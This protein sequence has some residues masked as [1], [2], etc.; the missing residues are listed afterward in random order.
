MTELLQN[1]MKFVQLSIYG[2]TLHHYFAKGDRC[3][4]AHLN[5][6]RF[7]IFNPQKTMRHKIIAFFVT[8]ALMQ[9]ALAAPGI[10]LWSDNFNTADTAD[11]NAAS[12]TGRLSGTLATSALLFSSIDNDGLPYRIVDNQ[13]RTSAFEGNVQFRV[14]GT[15]TSFDWAASAEA[16]TILAAGGIRVEFDHT[17]PNTT[18]ENWVGIN[19][20]IND[21]T[22]GAVPPIRVNHPQTDYGIL[23]RDNGETVRIDNGLGL[24]NGSAAPTTSLR[25][26]VIEYA[27]TSFA[28]GASV[29]A[30][31]TVNGTPIA[32]DTFT[33]DGNSGMIFMQLETVEQGHLIDNFTVSTLTEPVNVLSVT[34]VSRDALGNIVINFVGAPSTTYKVTKSADLIVPFGP[35]GT[36]LS[37][38][39]NASGVGQVTVPASEA[40]ETK[41]FYRIETL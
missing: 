39:T 29:L 9:T 7:L 31:T 32:S 41:E 4:E 1:N 26:I 19:I 10:V 20:G 11:F 33:W 34:G 8:G 15:T 13:L 17:P 24:G 12:L 22:G 2:G 18:S 6:I 35:L 21:V 38:M 40:S 30:T 37:A 36:P 5:S 28:D 14:P 25:H 27:F 16:A 3:I 23:F